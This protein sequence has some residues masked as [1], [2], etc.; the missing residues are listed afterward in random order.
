[1]PD[2]SALHDLILQRRT[3]HDYTREA[4]DDAAIERALVAAIH[5]PNH[6][7][8]TPWRF[9]RV[10]RRTREGLADI[11]VGHR[12]KPGAPLDPARVA[13]IRDKLLAPHELI[14]V[15]LVRTT[16]PAIAR[17]DYASAA[18]AIQNLHLALWADGIGSKWSTGKVSQDPQSYALLGVD[19][20][21]EEIIG[22]VWVGRAKTVPAKPPRPELA[23]VV[24]RLP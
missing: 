5:A 21:R 22:F 1:M 12:Q 7:M 10:G 24:R 3:I 6:R 23:A 15:S 11:A 8:T 9:V 2:G 13:E 14:V 16:D 4:V 17:E 20:A 18:C 19:P